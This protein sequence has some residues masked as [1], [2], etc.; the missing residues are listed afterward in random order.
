MGAV[1]LVMPHSDTNAAAPAG[2]LRARATVWLAAGGI[3]LAVWAVYGCTL[4]DPFVFDDIPAVVDNPSIR[5]HWPPGPVLVP[6]AD[7][8]GASGRPLFNFSLALNYAAGGLAVE[9]YR[10]VDILLHALAALALFGV[11][12]RTLLLPTAGAPSSGG[13]P[14]LQA[15]RALPLAFAVALVW[16]VL[17]LLTETVSAVVIRADLL[18]GLFYLLTIYG[19]ARGATARHPARWHAAAVAACLV[20]MASKE[21]VVSAPL[22]A[23]LY[24]RAF[25]AGTFADAWRRRRGWYLALAGTWVL[26]ALLMVA[27]RHRNET[28]G[29]GLGVSAWTYALTQCWAIVRYLRLCFWPAPLVFDYDRFLVH[30]PLA[31]LPQALGLAVLLVATLVALR[32]RPALGFLGA[33]FFAILAPSSSVVPLTTQTVA[34]HRMYLPL[35]AVIVLVAVGLR[36]VAGRRAV[37]VLLA[38][39]VAGGWQT[40]QRNRDFRSEFAIWS[41][42]VA[43]W[44]DNARVLKRLGVM[45][46]KEGRTGEAIARYRQALRLAPHDPET[47]EALGN[48]LYRSGRLDE[49]IPVYAEALRLRPDLAAVHNNLGLALARQGH[50]AE[51]MAEYRA[52]LRFRPAYAEAHNNL[53]VALMQKEEVAAATVQFREALRANPDFADAHLNLGNVLLNGGRE[54]AAV[55]E[56]EAALRAKPGLVE[57]HANLGLVLADLGRFPE[58]IRQFEAVLR[59]RPDDAE[60]REALARLRAGPP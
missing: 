55:A 32:R 38:L 60:A 9:S 51:A 41:D 11:V 35:A 45:L 56:Y 22:L 20:G 39:A 59:L 18:A 19:F 57:A 24:D 44:P 16:A 40:V 21:W 5:H 13:G 52:A 12:R 50:L 34:E 14:R 33:W 2:T 23:L 6:P 28:V 10:A 53:G 4:H 25:L 48:A 36:A 47:L 26:L 42:T 3:F 46:A 1:V 7:S 43:K 29:F 17:P 15:D 37:S 58:A 49:A 30:D 54:E 31:V 27:S 8:G